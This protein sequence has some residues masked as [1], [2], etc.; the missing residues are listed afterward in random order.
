M[1]QLNMNVCMRYIEFP[2]YQTHQQID[3]MFDNVNNCLIMNNYHI[4]IIVFPL[5]CIQFQQLT[6]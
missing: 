3:R 5:A 6:P 1:K 2:T 4:Y